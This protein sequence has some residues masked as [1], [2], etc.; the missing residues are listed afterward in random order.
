MSRGFAGLLSSLYVRLF[1]NE[2]TI[3]EYFRKQGAAIVADGSTMTT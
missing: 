2:Y 3:A 1:Y